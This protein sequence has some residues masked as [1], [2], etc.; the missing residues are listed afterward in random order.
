MVYK[1]SDTYWTS[2]SIKI[3]DHLY[4][5]FDVHSLWKDSTSFLLFWVFQR[6]FHQNSNENYWIYSSDNYYTTL[7]TWFAFQSF[8]KNPSW[9]SS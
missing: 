9:T 3:S 8:L 5:Y 6:I 1:H 2:K 4:V 7:A